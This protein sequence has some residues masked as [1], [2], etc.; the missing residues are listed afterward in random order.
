MTKISSYYNFGPILS[1]N[2]MINMIIGARGLGKTYGAKLR[3]IKAA[4]RKREQ[5]IYL[6]RY[7]TELE[8]RHTFFADIERHNAFPNYDFRVQGMEA[9]M[10]PKSTRDEKNREWQTIGFFVALSTAQKLK[11]KSYPLVTTMIFD[12][13]IL[14]KGALHYLP[15][16]VD[17]FLNLYSTVDRW[18]DRVRVLMLANS[19]SIMAPYFSKWD[20]TPDM[21]ADGERAIREWHKFGGG[22]GVAHFPEAAQFR[23]EAERTRFGRFVSNTA[24]GDFAMTNRFADN[25]D[26]LIG[27]K[28]RQ[29]SYVGTIK[30]ASGEKFSVWKDQLGFSVQEKLPKDEVKYSMSPVG[31][32]DDETLLTKSSP[33]IKVLRSSFSHGGMVFDKPFTR[34]MFI[35]AV[36]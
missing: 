21:A 28:T 9:H 13:F 36:I 23:A 6:R 18:E 4:I 34:N 8:S 30:V 7:T 20:I 2:A 17:A 27:S 12:E 10:A 29:A 31:L 3:V 35:K 11:S 15:N 14:E 24:Y 26:N 1:R 33:L 25:H 5:F 19:V 22:F 16:E 32:A